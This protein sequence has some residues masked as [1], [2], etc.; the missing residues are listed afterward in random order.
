MKKASKALVNTAP[1][2]MWGIRRVEPTR[3]FLA[4]AVAAAEHARARVAQAQRGGQV[5]SELPRA[6]VDQLLGEA[7][8]SIDRAVERLLWVLNGAE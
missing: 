6:E 8:G 4:G 7:A 3:P 1:G 2:G 5:R